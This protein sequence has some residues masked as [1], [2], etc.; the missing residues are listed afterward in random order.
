MA[1]TQTRLQQ[2]SIG[3]TYPRVKAYGQRVAFL[4]H[5]HHDGA[6]AIGLQAL[7]RQQGLDL[8]IDWQDAEMPERPSAETA[9]RLRTRIKEANLFLYLATQNSA[10]SR[11]CPWELGYADG[12][13]NIAQILVIPTLDGTTE[14]GAE[15][16]NLYQRIDLNA[17]GA[18]EVIQPGRSFG[19][20]VRSF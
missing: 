8:Y 13:K 1:I 2:A 17:A 14:H 9:S 16:I 20:S 7:L 3:N 18:L 12:V 15:Y 11:W 5:S 6:L 10:R 4:C 19:V